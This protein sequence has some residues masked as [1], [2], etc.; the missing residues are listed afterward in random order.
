MLVDG[1]RQQSKD[2]ILMSVLRR[3][4]ENVLF[5]AILAK[6]AEVLEPWPEARLARLL[7]TGNGPANRRWG[8]VDSGGRWS[9]GC[10]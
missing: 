1:L 6:C 8:T 9:V 4:C 3:V 10:D 5:C 2:L 7:S